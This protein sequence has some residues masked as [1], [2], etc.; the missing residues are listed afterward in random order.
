M[1]AGPPDKWGRPT[2]LSLRDLAARTNGQITHAMIGHV[3]T[4]KRE[5]HSPQKI[6]ALAEALNVPFAELAER[7]S[8]QGQ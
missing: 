7:A 5:L 8:Y 6:R 4:G 1:S 2:P 3:E